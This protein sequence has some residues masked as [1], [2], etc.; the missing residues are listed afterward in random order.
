MK[1][2]FFTE[3]SHSIGLGHLK[4]CL[5]LATEFEDDNKLSIEIIVP[6]INVENLTI[7]QKSKFSFFRL[8]DRL[9]NLREQK[10]SAI[11]IIVDV[12]SEYYDLLIEEFHHKNIRIFGIDDFTKRSLNYTANFGPPTT[13]IPSNIQESKKEGNYTGWNWV[14]I[15]REL[16]AHTSEIQNKKE[17]NVLLMFG[18][19]DVEELS[20]PS[21]KHFAQFTGKEHFTI[22]CGPLVPESQFEVCRDTASKS[23]NMKVLKS[24]PNLYEV[25]SINS[26]SITSFG[27]TFYELIALKNHPLGIYRDLNEVAGLLSRNS[28]ISDLLISLDEYRNLVSK[29]LNLAVHKYW[30]SKFNQTDELVV[31]IDYLSEQ[32]RSGCLNIKDVVY[33][34][35]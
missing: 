8:K 10:A 6:E 24:P 4:R 35:I 34:T 7:L 20:I 33:N 3:A 30:N 11:F 1:V 17:T 19:S 5:A 27:H 29:N 26:F 31:F 25:M 28:P 16:W 22:V 18:G 21:C 23:K 2:V 15:H 32:L 12:K 14:P 9:E 13:F